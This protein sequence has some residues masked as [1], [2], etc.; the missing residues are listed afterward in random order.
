M[1]RIKILVMDVDGTLTDGKIYIGNQGE[2]M[3]SFSVKDGYAI[4]KLLPQFGIEPI[5]ITGRESNILVNRCKELGIEKVYQ[6]CGDKRERLLEIAVSKGLS[7]INDVILGCACIGD[8]IPDIPC[9]RVSEI[10]GC[11]ADAVSE[12]KDVVTYICNRNS[13]DG[14]VREFVEWIIKAG[15]I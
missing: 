11:P 5:V 3:K 15:R 6:N 9:M 4:G 2:I 13:G 1:N 10:S 12:V 8:D 7:V 14:A